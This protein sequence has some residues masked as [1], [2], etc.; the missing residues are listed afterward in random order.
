MRLRNQTGDLTATVEPATLT[1]ANGSVTISRTL[2]LMTLTGVSDRRSWDRTMNGRPRSGT[3]DRETSAVH[4]QALWKLHAE[5][6]KQHRED[7]LHLDHG[8]HVADAPPRPSPK[9]NELVR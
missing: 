5:T 1:V 3:D 8:E 9:G 2:P 6:L 7:D 4:S